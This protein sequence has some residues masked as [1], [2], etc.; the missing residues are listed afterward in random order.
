M[1]PATNSNE[2]PGR[3]GVT[4]KPVSRKTIRKR[5]AYTHAPYVCAR[6]RRCW[7]RCRTR[8]TKPEN[9]S[10][11]DPALLD[12]G[13]F[14]LLLGLDE[15]LARDAQ[16]HHQ[17]ARNQDRR[18]YAEQD[19]DGERQRKI[20]QRLAADDQDRRDHQLRAAVGD[21]GARHSAGDG[22]VDDFRRTGLA[23][24]AEILAN[25]V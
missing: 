7:S 3:N 11:E 15:I 2:S 17:R 6:S 10:M 18:I 19:A 14:L 20:V 4:T 16:P 25:P 9:R 22:V 1:V 13:L 12:D 8:S 23:H 24:L 21:D 5:T